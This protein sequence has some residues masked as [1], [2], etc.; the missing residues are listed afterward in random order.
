MGFDPCNFPLTIWKSI[1]SVR[2]HSFTLS[3][4][5]GSRRCDS[6]G[7]FL[8]RNLASPYFGR[9]TMVKVVTSWNEN[10]D[11]LQIQLT[12]CR[13]GWKHIIGGPTWSISWHVYKVYTS[14]MCCIVIFG[15]IFGVWV[16]HFDFHKVNVVLYYLKKRIKCKLLNSRNNCYI[17]GICIIIKLVFYFKLH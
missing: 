5:P 15:F 16:S 12:N 13:F 6:W 3:C 4:T 7:S 17:Y 9:K 8:T 1:G 2:G 14:K 11:L 10:I